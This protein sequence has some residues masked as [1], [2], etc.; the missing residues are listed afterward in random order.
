M[1]PTIPLWLKTDPVVVHIPDRTIFE[2]QRRIIYFNGN[3]HLLDVCNRR[4]PLAQ[5]DRLRL[6]YLNGVALWVT[7][8]QPLTVFRVTSQGNVVAVTDGIRKAFVRFPAATRERR[9]AESLAAFF[10]GVVVE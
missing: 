9:A 5:C 4:Y 1:T 7:E 8:G 6:D 3:P 10:D 2:P